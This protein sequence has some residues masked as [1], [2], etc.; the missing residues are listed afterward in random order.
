MCLWPSL[1]GTSLGGAGHLTRAVVRFSRVRRHAQALF[2]CARSQP[3][4]AATKLIRACPTRGMMHV[5]LMALLLLQLAP[6]V[7]ASPSGGHVFA[8]HAALLTA[9]DAWCTDS[10]SARL[11]YGEINTW[12]ISQ[13]T[14]LAWVFCSSCSTHA[15]MALCQCACRTFNDDISSW[16]TSRITSLR[17]YNPPHFTPTRPTLLLGPH[18]CL[19]HCRVLLGA[20]PPSTSPSLPGTWGASQT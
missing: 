18:V 15:S 13:V 12:D 20:Q 7:E 17:V 3:V 1:R 4:R 5:P 9:R 6:P 2:R 11:T 8:D 10:G 14:S 19:P 16:D